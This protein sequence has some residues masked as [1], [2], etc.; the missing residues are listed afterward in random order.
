MTSI[1][2]IGIFAA[3][4]LGINFPF[5]VIPSI[6]VISVTLFWAGLFLG[7][8]NGIA[9]AAI[10]GIIFVYFNPNGPQPIV[11]VGIA[12]IAGFVTFALTGGIFRSMLLNKD[13]AIKTVITMIVLGA[14]LTFWYDLITNIMFAL[15]IGPFWV[16]LIGG[17]S[18]ATAH[19]ISNAIIFGFSGA[20]VNK[21]WKRLE[22]SL[23]PLTG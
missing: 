7:W 4:A 18:F 6:E 22:N 3:L 5:L 14:F 1:A 11:L 12:Q 9:A 23:P 8:R 19:I 15:T 21:V 17:L 20:L 16:V 2:R 10:A 13:N